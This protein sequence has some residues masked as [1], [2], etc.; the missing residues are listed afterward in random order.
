MR[1]V[2]KI[3]SAVI[4]ATFLMSSF[5]IVAFA[6]DGDI[7]GGVLPN[8]ATDVQDCKDVMKDF[9]AMKRED[10]EKML[11]SGGAE[12]TGDVAGGSADGEAETTANGM[13]SDQVL[14]CGIK[15]GN[16]SFWMVPYYVKYLLE[17]VI[18]IAG[19]ISV[20]GIVVGG[21]MYLFAGLSQDKDKGKNAIKNALIGLVLTLTAWAIV[22]IV[23]ALVTA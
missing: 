7:H 4:L 9:N 23:I 12:G 17:F 6:A 1:F 16:I 13:T 19:L 2:G 15:T 21:F 22:N 5:G 10:A 3:I 14:G 20:G 18:G 11:I 8:T